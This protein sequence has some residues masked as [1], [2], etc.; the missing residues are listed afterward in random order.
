MWLCKKIHKGLG[1]ML[2]HVEPLFGHLRTKP[3]G[4]EWTPAFTS[5]SASS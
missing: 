5:Q 2:Q 3:E 4:L 1:V